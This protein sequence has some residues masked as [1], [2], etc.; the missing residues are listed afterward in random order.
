VKQASSVPGLTRGFCLEKSKV[1]MSLCQME[2]VAVSG[3][4]D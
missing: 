3:D 1:K 4:V 2:T